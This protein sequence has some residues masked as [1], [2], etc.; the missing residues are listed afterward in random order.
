[1]A[2]DSVVSLLSLIRER[3]IIKKKNIESITKSIDRCESIIL[4]IKEFRKRNYITNAG[5]EETELLKEINRLNKEKRT[6]EMSCWQDI[7]KLIMNS[8]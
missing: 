6:E 8:K 1:M 5:R 2:R 7:T 3:E 4:N